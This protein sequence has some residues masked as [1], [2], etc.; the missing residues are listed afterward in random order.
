MWVM[1]RNGIVVVTGNSGKTQTVKGI[2]DMLVDNNIT[3]AMAAPTARAS[4]VIEKYTGINAT[5]IHRLLAWGRDNKPFY[6]ESCP[7]PMR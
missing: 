4:K 3:F 2:V 7:L 1:R 5:T 6:N